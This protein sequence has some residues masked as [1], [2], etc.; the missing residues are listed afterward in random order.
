MTGFGI[1]DKCQMSNLVITIIS[2]A[3]AAIIAIM[4]MWYG[5]SAFTN[6][7][8]NAQATT[9]IVQ[10]DQIANAIRLWSSDNGG[11]QDLA[12]SRGNQCRLNSGPLGTAL[13]NGKYLQSIPGQ[14]FHSS[15]C[16]NTPMAPG[17]WT[18]SE[19]DGDCNT[20]PFKILVAAFGNNTLLQTGCGF[21][22]TDYRQVCN[23]INKVQGVTTI[24]NNTSWNVLLSTLGKYTFICEENYSF[25]GLFYFVYRVF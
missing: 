1:G 11:A 6:S 15:I 22:T 16:N 17:T 10:A 13:I 23:A 7:S 4:G 8:A 24:P 2:I 20:T 25:P 5:G 12:G 14:D 18:I 21:P 3:L 9:M 19:G